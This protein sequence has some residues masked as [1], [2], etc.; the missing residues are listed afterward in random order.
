MHVIPRIEEIM[1]VAPHVIGK[2]MPLDEA[3]AIMRTLQIRHLPVLD[4]GAIVGVLCDRDIKFAHSLFPD[5]SDFTVGD[6]MTREPYTVEGCA[7]ADEV[8]REMGLRKVGCVIIRNELNRPIGI[9]TAG[10]AVRLFGEFLSHIGSSRPP[11]AEAV[12]VHPF[13]R[14]LVKTF[15]AAGI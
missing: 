10:D 3:R 6:A 11:T 15:S 14:G 12:L 8:L 2:D 1:T 7:P 4:D 9:L 13:I 5:V